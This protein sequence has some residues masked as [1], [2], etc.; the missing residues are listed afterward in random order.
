MKLEDLCLKLI[1]KRCQE[2]MSGLT[3]DDREAGELGEG[4][5]ECFN[6]RG[7][8]N[9]IILERQHIQV[10][11]LQSPGALPTAGSHPMVSPS[12]MPEAVLFSSRESC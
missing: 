8:K 10:S 6:L 7:Q 9:P 2:K 11:L 4:K 1:K 3:G 12:L 5:N